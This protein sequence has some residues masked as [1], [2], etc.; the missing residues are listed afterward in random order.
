MHSKS[1]TLSSGLISSENSETKVIRKNFYENVSGEK[2]EEKT[3]NQGNW[4][5]KICCCFFRNESGEVVL[6][7]PVSIKRS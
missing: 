1:G 2:Q 3:I 7:S 4:G 5:G 6:K